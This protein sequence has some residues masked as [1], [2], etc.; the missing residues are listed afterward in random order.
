MELIDKKGNMDII[1]DTNVWYN[2]ANGSIAVDELDKI[3]L[4][5]TFINLI[6][7][8]RTPYILKNLSL[9]QEA[10]KSMYKYHSS[11]FE[12]NPFEYIILKQY[13]D[14]KCIDNQF[15]TILKSFERLMRINPM[16]IIDEK[17]IIEMRLSI[18]N[19]KLYL[20]QTTNSVN[21]LLPTIR[22]NIKK[23][24][25]KKIHRNMDS[26]SIIQE[27]ISELI[28]L[29][30]KGSIKLDIANYPWKEIELMMIVLDNYFK[31]LELSGNQKMSPNDW[32]DIFN[33]VY[34]GNDYK[35]T[36]REKTWTRLIKSDKRTES[37]LHE[38]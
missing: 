23:T 28:N 8:S 34:V 26:M 21:E 29:Y 27:L 3:N 16:A 4:Y 1:C 20:H 17:Y 7:L 15:R 11:I 35:Y 19:Y 38:L 24:T 14:Y 18:G 5:P 22:E 12:I 36:T 25:G 33:M 37:Y 10:V 32:S 13:A 30:S 2:I 9:V 6:E 31:E